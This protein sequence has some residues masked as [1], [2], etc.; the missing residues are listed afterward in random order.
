M[1]LGFLGSPSFFLAACVRRYTC[2]SSHTLGAS[3]STS[4]QSRTSASLM[5]TMQPGKSLLLVFVECSRVV[6]VHSGLRFVLGLNCGRA[7]V[8]TGRVAST[9][10]RYQHSMVTASVGS[11]GCCLAVPFPARQLPHLRR[12]GYWCLEQVD[13]HFCTMLLC[14]GLMSRISLSSSRFHDHVC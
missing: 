6:Q 13:A 3:S 14:L 5:K 12:C 7:E 8:A 10:A 4:S 2:S 1:M 11:S 9:G